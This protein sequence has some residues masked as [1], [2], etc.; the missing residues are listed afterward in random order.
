MSDN[1]TGGLDTPLRR[2]AAPPPMRDGYR[3]GPGATHRNGLPETHPYA[4]NDDEEV[5]EPA[6]IVRALHRELGLRYYG[7]CEHCEHKPGDPPHTIRCDG[8]CN[9]AQDGEQP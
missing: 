9:D 5:A 6:E 4:W 8:G 1:S 7:C 2:P 3:T